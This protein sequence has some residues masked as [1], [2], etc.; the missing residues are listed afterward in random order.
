[1]SVV[2]IALFEQHRNESLSALETDCIDRTEI[3]V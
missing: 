2:L 3:A 1:M